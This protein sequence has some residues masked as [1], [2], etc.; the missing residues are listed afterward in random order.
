MVIKRKVIFRAF[1]MKKNPAIKKG[2]V[3]VIAL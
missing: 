3:A 1:K 2:L